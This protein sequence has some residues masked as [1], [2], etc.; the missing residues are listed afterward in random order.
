MQNQKNFTNKKILFIIK[1]IFIKQNEK[2]NTI[3]LKTPKINFNLNLS[4]QKLT[5]KK[6]L[7]INPIKLNIKN[8]NS[9]KLYIPIIKN[10][11]QKNKIKA[12]KKTLQKN[13]S[14]YSLKLNKKA[15][16]NKKQCNTK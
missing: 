15:T 9:I 10:K 11:F 5:I 8:S 16:I 14:Q 2:I 3:T 7:N 13:T 12:I 6:K 1:Q 4:I